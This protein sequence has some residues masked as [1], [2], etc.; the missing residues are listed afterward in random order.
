M[1]TLENLKNKYK[2]L[3]DSSIIL[4]AEKESKKLKPEVLDIL[5]N[6]I[7]KRD[8][9]LNLISWIDAENN[10]FS[11]LEKKQLEEK[12]RRSICCNCNERSGLKGHE[13]LQVYSFIF[14]S[15]KTKSH[16]ILCNKCGVDEKFSAFIIT[17]FFGWWSVYG[18][19]FTLSTLYEYILNIFF[20]EKIDRRIIHNFIEKNTGKIRLYGDSEDTF[21]NLLISFNEKRTHTDF[22]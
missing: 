10:T 15:N 4:L 1:N 21:N 8:L 2:T 20:K 12:I 3:S 22:V 9:D 6:E 19:F 13:I 18:F 7:I 5:K 14:F 16:L 17:I 11:G